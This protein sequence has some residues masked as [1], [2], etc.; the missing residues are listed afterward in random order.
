MIK[1]TLQWLHIFS[2]S[3]LTDSSKGYWDDMWMT[4]SWWDLWEQVLTMFYFIYPEYWIINSLAPG[5]CKSDFKSKISEHVLWIL[6]NGTSCEI[7]FSWMLHNTFDGNSTLIQ[8]MTWCHWATS[9]YL[10]QSWPR[11]MFPFG[12]SRPQWVVVPKPHFTIKMPYCM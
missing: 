2:G 4:H 10:I 11:C 1:C 9:H 5:I 12:V 6:F 7:A 3:C 8:I